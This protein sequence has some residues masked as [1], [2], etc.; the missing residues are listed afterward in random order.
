MMMVF[1]YEYTYQDCEHRIKTMNTQH[2]QCTCYKHGRSVP[3]L[4]AAHKIASVVL[5]TSVIKLIGQAMLTSF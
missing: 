1:V 3:L 2:A 5:S 4:Q